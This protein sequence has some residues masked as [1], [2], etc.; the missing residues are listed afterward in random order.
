MRIGREDGR[1]RAGRGLL[2]LSLAIGA[3]FAATGAGLAQAPADTPTN[4]FAADPAAAEAGRAVFESTCAACHGPGA[5]G[6]R[7]PA[8]NTG[9]FAHGGQD[10][11]IFH[12]IQEGVPS[13]G[14]PSFKALPTQ[15]VWRVVSY[16]RSL[17]GGATAAVAAPADPAAVARGEKIFFGAGQCAS[18][19]EVNGR[20]RAVAADLSNIGPAGGSL[21]DRVLHKAAPPR[22]GLGRAV[23][24]RQK[25]GAAVQGLVRA[26]DAFN[27]LVMARDGELRRYDRRALTSVRTLPEG[28]APR[29]VA[30]RLKPAELDD[31]VA[32]LSSQK[33]RSVSGAIAPSGT[34]GLSAKRLVAG[35]AEPQNW[36]TYWGDYQGRHFSELSQIT[37]RNVA[38]LQARWAAPLPGG[39]PVQATPI[40]VDGVIYVSGPPGDLYAIDA[41]S[42]LQIWAFKRKQDVTNPYQ[43]NPANRGVAVLDG[44]VFMTTLDNLLI[45]VDA[46]TGRELWERRVADTLQGYEMT[47]APLAVG[48]KIVVGIGCGEFAARGFLEAYSPVDGRKLWHFE[49]IPKPGEPGIETWAGESWKHGGG[50]TW[51]T[52]SYDPALR[53]LYWAVGN[54]APSFNPQ[55]RKGDNLYTNSVIALDPD[56]GKL[57][58]WYQF[59]PNDSHDWD[60]VQDL[61]LADRVI[62]GKP[63]K[64]LLHA[65]RNGFF[66]VLDRTDGSFISAKPFTRQTWNNGFDPK[67]R[68]IVRPDSIS[69]PQGHPVFPAVGGTNFQ[70]PSYDDRTGA[71]Y[72]AFLDAEGFAAFGP[73][74]LEPGKLYTSASR[75]PRPTPAVEPIFGIRALDSGTGKVLWTFPTTR[76]ALAPGVLGTRGGVLFASTADGSL[77]GLDMASGAPLW[78]FRTGVTM[79]ASP[80]SYAL[81]GQQYVAVAAGNMLY[82]FALPDLAKETRR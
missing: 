82:S 77:V 46:R 23:E 39:S 33:G 11:E 63:R 31:V 2:T 69:T 51:L 54:P 42:G 10:Y 65:D 25:D 22:S 41:R 34:S 43:I 3:V 36:P 76:G 9:R 55:V 44:R 21:R 79:S 62:D 28:L 66:Y 29:D 70:A 24:V 26:E 19:H 1:G 60:S 73:P 57:K 30:E 74:K 52:G 14:M 13:A 35:R 71:F 80:I 53:T 47:G 4:P 59:T 18:C 37:P 64:V 40:V 49:T 61:V 15:D 56:T 16:L 72:L 8:L 48:D 67:G 17:S 6:G 78:T 81:D 68:P 20:G 75:Q 32:Y 45:A 7:G 5:S 38:G 50:G 58:W 12:T 27:L